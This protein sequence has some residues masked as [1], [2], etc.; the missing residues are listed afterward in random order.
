MDQ[1]SNCLAFYVRFL[2]TWF[3]NPVPILSSIQRTGNYIVDDELVKIM[4]VG[5]ICLKLE[6]DTMNDG[7][8][9]TS[10]IGGEFTTQVLSGV[11]FAPLAIHPHLKTK[12]PS[13]VWNPSLQC[14]YPPEF[15]LASMG[16]LMC[17]NSELVQ[18]PPRLPSREERFNAAAMLPKALWLEIL[19]FTHRK[20]R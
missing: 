8:D 11:R 18:P 1:V 7:D 2:S 4:R 10:V 14:L 20:C 9:S 15:Q 19:S 17:S 5:N 13:N 3:I 16:V 6:A 12:I